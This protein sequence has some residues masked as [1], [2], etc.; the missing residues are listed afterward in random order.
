M[1]YLLLYL[2][3][4]IPVFKIILGLIAVYLIVFVTCTLNDI[5]IQRYLDSVGIGNEDRAEKKIDEIELKYFTIIVILISLVIFTPSKKFIYS[6][7]EM[8]SNKS[9]DLIYVREFK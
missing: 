1:K 5:K 9:N 6:I 8:N 2:I 4:I 3:E 7:L